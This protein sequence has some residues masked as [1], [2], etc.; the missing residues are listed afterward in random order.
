MGAYASVR[1]PSG[2]SLAYTCNY[3]IN[4][5]TRT[6]IA[7]LFSKLF[8]STHQNSSI[9]KCFQKFLHE[10]TLMGA[11]RG[12]G[13]RVGRRPPLEIFFHHIGGP[14][15]YFFLMWLVF[16]WELELFFF[17]FFRERASFKLT[18]RHHT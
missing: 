10:D 7:I 6:E 8:Q 16:D 5:S 1:I 14:F 11:R 3:N 13:A 12:R 17:F 15:C 2:P 9:V 4:T 18:I